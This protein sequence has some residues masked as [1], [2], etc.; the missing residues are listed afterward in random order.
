MSELFV[1]SH[2]GNIFLKITVRAR[3]VASPLYHLEM[4]RSQMSSEASPRSALSLPGV[5]AWP[6]PWKARS[7][8]KWQRCSSSTPLREAA[9]ANILPAGGGTKPAWVSSVSPCLWWWDIRPASDSGLYLG[10]R[11]PCA[12]RF[13]LRKKRF[14]QDGKNK[15][16]WR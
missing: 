15:S 13:L 10:L 8:L 3:P 5:P 7:S 6:R 14:F 16:M 1:L 2:F 4:L 11:L 12:D 9:S